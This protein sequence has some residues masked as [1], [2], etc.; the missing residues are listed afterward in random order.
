MT[1]ARFLRLGATAALFAV[2][3]WRLDIGA[4][5][6][7]FADI[8]AVWVLAALTLTVPQVVL[9]AWR[10]RLTAHEI[11]LS[12]PFVP[13]VREYYLATFLNQ[14]LPGGVLGDATR[15]WRHARL[16]VDAGDAW[17]AVV[18]ERVSGQ[19]SLG[20]ITLVALA[21][22]SPLRTGLGAAFDRISVGG[23]I[24]AL[25]ACTVLVIAALFGCVR[26]RNTAAGRRARRFIGHTRDN[27]FSSRIGLC[28]FVSSLLV[29][30]SYV[31]VFLLSA[32]AIGVERSLADLWALA[33]LVLLAMAIPL[34]IA[35]WGLRE[36]AA[37]VVWMLAGLPA[38]EGVAVSLTYG[39]IVLLSS[40]PGAV[41]LITR[42]RIRSYPDRH[43]ADV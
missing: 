5:A 16:E 31:G 1:S 10:W 30:A 26:L 18:I 25:G 9:S 12:L 34:S 36:G 17:H 41:V 35:G 22:S 8:Q 28:Q 19:L 39:A 42:R 4:L 23:P 32:R 38:S 13:A 29:V 11:G 27:L 43:A 3:Y 40:L 6:D 7:E 14:V 15:A 33:P 24:A 2:L 37:A 21:C 20:L